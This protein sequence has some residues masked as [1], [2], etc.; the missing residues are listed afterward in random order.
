[1]LLVVA[2]TVLKVSLEMGLFW[3]QIAC[4]LLFTLC[5][6]SILRVLYLW[7]RKA[8]FER[9]ERRRTEHPAEKLD[10]PVG[11]RR[12]EQYDGGKTLHEAQ[13]TY[14]GRAV[15]AQ[16]NYFASG[17]LAAVLPP[18]ALL[19]LSFQLLALR[20]GGSWAIGLIL[21]EVLC[22]GIL[23][24]FALTRREPTAE[25][26]ENR[27]R[28]EL[29][30]REQYLFLGGV[31][32][33][34]AK[35]PPKAAEEALR[36]RSE[37]EGADAHSLIGLVPLQERS[38]L[39]WLEALHHRG[40]SKLPSRSDCIERMESYRYYRIGKQLLWFA[41]EL[42]DCEENERLWSQLLTGALLA[43]IGIA[44]VHA[45]QLA[46]SLVGGDASHG[47]GYWDVMIGALGIVLPP[48]GTACLS[49]RAMYNFRGRS[50]IYEHEKGSLHAH[51]GT[52]DALILEAKNVQ[53]NAARSRNLD[54]IDFDFRAVALRTEH[55]LSVE[56]DQWMLM[57]ERR[58]HELSP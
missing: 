28:T 5:G 43:A 16:G 36:R 23:V 41:N 8:S 1:M 20:A 14:I 3:L 30:R 48:L 42:R 25:W 10:I 38:G 12:L 51:K 27:I 39:S 31:G 4:P 44:A 2:L 50:R 7:Q 46:K 19:L 15:E 34:L 35:E 40:S 54:K 52:L 22:L 11:V 32:P 45:F 9:R 33:Y 26:I 55:S 21:S 17:I 53:T 47:S 29:L 6:F 37:I 58:E 24:Y 18:L 56:M 49:I 57:M 13:W